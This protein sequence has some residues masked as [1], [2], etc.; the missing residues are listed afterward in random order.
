MVV[1]PGTLWNYEAWKQ[2]V[3]DQGEEPRT[4]LEELDKSGKF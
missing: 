1:I 3:K 4:A 2:A